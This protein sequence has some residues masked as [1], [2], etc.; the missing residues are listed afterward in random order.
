MVKK[1]VQ[2]F[3]ITERNLPNVLPASLRHTGT[4]K[5]NHAATLRARSS[6]STDPVIH[7]PRSRALSP[8]P[9]LF[10]SP[11]KSQL[12]GGRRLN[13][14]GK[15]LLQVPRSMAL[16]TT[17][18][19]VEPVIAEVEMNASSDSGATTVRATVVQASTV[20]YDTPATLGTRALISSHPSWVLQL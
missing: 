12:V 8:P 9:L 3:L 16:V 19:G 1:K 10:E 14:L 17:G 5:P 6:A 18:S 15:S 4:G 13:S 11:S 7:S 20:F 2:L